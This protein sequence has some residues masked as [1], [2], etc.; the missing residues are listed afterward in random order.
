MHIATILVPVDFTPRSGRALALASELAELVGGR[1]VLHHNE[2]S[3]VFAMGRGW[4]WETHS[5]VDH[6]STTAVEAAMRRLLAQVPPGI[7]VEA[8]LSRGLPLPT[9]L[10]LAWEL[11]ADLIVVASHGPDTPHHSS[12][13]QRLLE[14]A[15]CP[16]LALQEDHDERLPLLHPP[17][18]GEP[19]EVLVATDFSPAGDTAVRYALELLDRLPALRLRLVHVVP[20]V[21][22]SSAPGGSEAPEVSG[23]AASEAHA[24]LLER[25]PEGARERTSV[26]VLAGRPGTAIVE[27]C[28]AHHVSFVVMGEHATGLR[29]FLTHDTAREVLR[30]AHCPVWYV[31]QPMSHRRLL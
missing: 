22:A 19:S 12:V 15:P 20:R 30:S 5:H 16:V 11:P 2:A 6:G 7:P 27:A 23:R 26:E 17:L 9:I 13:T 31:P 8:T 3:A 10:A 4:E 21:L 1:L 29:G 18:E 14:Q 28:A 24:R 25:V